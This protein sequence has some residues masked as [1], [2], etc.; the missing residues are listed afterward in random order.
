RIA[1]GCCD[2]NLL[3]AFL[4]RFSS[5][6]RNTLAVDEDFDLLFRQSRF[7]GDGIKLSDAKLKAQRAVVVGQFL[8]AFFVFYIGFGV[9]WSEELFNETNRVAKFYRKI[10]R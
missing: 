7:Y 4:S 9:S 5:G 10:G 6:T 3:R 1:V 2:P 8:V